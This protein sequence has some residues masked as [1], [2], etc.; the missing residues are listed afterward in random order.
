M[1]Y[2]SAS[3]TV[4][5]VQVLSLNSGKIFPIFSDTRPKLMYTGAPM[6]SAIEGMSTLDQPVSTLRACSV[7]PK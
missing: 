4:S 7:V 3:S 2:A 1:V 6:R 5:M